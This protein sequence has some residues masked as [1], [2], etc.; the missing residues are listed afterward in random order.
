V[1][2]GGDL[3]NLNIIVLPEKPSNLSAT[4]LSSTQIDLSWSD[5]SSNELGF[6]I[7][8]KVSGG[9]YSEI[10]RVGANVTTYSDKNCN[11]GTIYTYRVRAHNAA[12]DSNFSN[13]ASATTLSAGGGG[14]QDDVEAFVT[15]FYEECLGRSPEPAGLMFWVNSLI[16]GSKTGSDVAR[17]FVKSTEFKNGN[18]SNEDYLK[19]LYKAFFD[20]RRTRS[21]FKHG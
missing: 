4:T 6:K 11:E 3:S 14:S 9:T 19:I 15:R 20:R 10:A 7:E 17:G 21:A 1:V 18:T 5:N 16:D 12:G 2:S 13:E 8:R